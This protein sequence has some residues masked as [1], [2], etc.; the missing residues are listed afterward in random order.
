MGVK[1]DTSKPTLRS[2]RSSS[3]AHK[4]TSSQAHKLTSSQAQKPVLVDLRH[5]DFNE[6][7]ASDS[8]PSWRA[9]HEASEDA[10]WIETAEYLYSTCK[11]LQKRQCNGRPTLLYCTVRCVQRPQDL[12]FFSVY[13]V[14]RHSHRRAARST[15][16]TKGTVP[17]T[18]P[19]RSTPTSLWGDRRSGSWQMRGSH[20]H[21]GQALLC[22]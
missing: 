3:Q 10:T 8:A 7:Q 14:T 17:P 20:C 2:A 12:T 15:V 22:K 11:D 4:L 9:S 5:V 19:T 13:P 21:R 16:P 18:Q 6:Q 1:E